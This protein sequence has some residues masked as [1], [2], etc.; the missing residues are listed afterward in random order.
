MTANVTFTYADRKGVLRV[1]NSAMRFRPPKTGPKKDGGPPGRP[2]PDGGPMGTA[3]ARA[4]PRPA[5]D[6]PPAADG[7][8]TV[9]VLEEQNGA[10]PRPLSIRTG[11]TDGSM[12]EVL[13]GTLREGQLVVVDLARGGPGPGGGGHVGRRGIF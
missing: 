12:T 6:S 4:G 5:Q 8:R 1:P 7:Q 2:A 3:K 13:E 11:V 9:W 10:D